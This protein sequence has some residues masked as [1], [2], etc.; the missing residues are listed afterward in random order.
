MT[1]FEMRQWL[2]N[3]Q[4]P[5]YNMIQA[6]GDAAYRGDLSPEAIEWQRAAMAFY[7]RL[8]VAWSLLY[9]GEHGALYPFA[10]IR[11]ARAL[12]PHRRERLCFEMTFHPPNGSH[13]GICIGCTLS[14][15]KWGTDTKHKHAANL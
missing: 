2:M 13:P 11:P 10:V 3:Y 6:V 15:P 9:L 7:G 5:A 12:P 8:H 14:S 4:L 1:A